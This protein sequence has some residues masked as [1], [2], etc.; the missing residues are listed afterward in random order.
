MDTYLIRWVILDKSNRNST[1]DD[2]S[3]WPISVDHTQKY[4]TDNGN[5][6]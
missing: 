2:S 3:I 4:S 5:V 1:E 6:I